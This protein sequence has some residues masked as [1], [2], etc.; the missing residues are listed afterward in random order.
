MT[1]VERIVK[2][3]MPGLL[4]YLKKKENGEVIFKRIEKQTQITHKEEKKIKIS[5]IDESEK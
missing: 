3:I 2:I 5:K 1:E 4:D